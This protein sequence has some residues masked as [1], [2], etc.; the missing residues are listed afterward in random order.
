MTATA[1]RKRGLPFKR[2]S[3]AAKERAIEW[4]RD[5]LNGDWFDPEPLTELFREH[6]AEHGF[7][8]MEA[9]WSLGHC[10]GDGVDI[11]GSIDIGKLAETD[12]FVLTCLAKGVLLGVGTLDDWDF[13]CKVKC[14]RVE[15]E[16]MCYS[17]AF[18][19]CQSAVD[20]IGLALK[21]HLNDLI[22]SLQRKLS[23]YGYDEINYLTS[24]ERAIES[25]EANDYSF[26][27][28]GDIL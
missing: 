27:C 14:S 26:D 10:Q 28:E 21:K 3:K 12:E 7:P 6:L 20:D 11:E 8:N 19:D 13:S 1:T 4:M 25:I 17:N 24:K 9:Y 23:K 5:K 2:L 16:W 15:L 18:H 22:Y